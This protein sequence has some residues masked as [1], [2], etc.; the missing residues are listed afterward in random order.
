MRNRRAKYAARY[1]QAAA[2][3]R[4]YIKG[5]KCSVCNQAPATECHHIA[6]RNSSARDEIF[7]LYEDERNW[8]PVCGQFQNGCH[9][10]VDKDG[11]W[12]CAAKLLMD[13]LDLTFLK[14]LRP[15][16]RFAFDL[17]ELHQAADDIKSWRY[18]R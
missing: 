6:G 16:R 18:L 13:E 8:L 3:R 14:T 9:S 12:S 2:R 15:G 1:E 5:K 4:L 10:K 11:L 17:S 7:A